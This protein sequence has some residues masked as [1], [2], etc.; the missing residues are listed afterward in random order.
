VQSLLMYDAPAIVR[1]SAMSR[2]P[3]VDANPWGTESA[4]YRWRMGWRGVV[5]EKAHGHFALVVT[6]GDVVKNL[7]PLV[8]LQYSFK[9]HGVVLDEF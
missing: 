8:G 3:L 7:V 4:Q 2:N 1:A 9:G 6:Q 5:R